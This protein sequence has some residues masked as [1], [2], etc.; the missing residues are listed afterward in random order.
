MTKTVAIRIL[1]NCDID[2]EEFMERNKQA[3]RMDKATFVSQLIW[4]QIEKRQSGE[5]CKE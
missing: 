5:D 3:Q 2:I 4:A 1:K